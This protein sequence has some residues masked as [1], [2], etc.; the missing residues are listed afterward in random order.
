MGLDR[1]IVVALSVIALILAPAA[2]LRALCVGH[3]CDEPTQ[4]TAGIPFCSLPDRQRDAII[5]GFREG[6]SPDVL[7]VSDSVADERVPLL[8]YGDGFD[9]V[10]IP[11]GTSLDR[12][13]PTLAQAID[14]RR[15]HPEVR[16]GVALE[17]APSST[18]AR[19]VLIVLLKGVGESNFDPKEI[20]SRRPYLD[21][22]AITTAAV[23]GSLPIDA[24]AIATTLGTGGLPYQHGIT[25][26]LIRNDAGR[27]VQA[28]GKGAP[29]S[30]IATLADDLDERS[31]QKARIGLVAT[32]PTDQGLVGGNWYLDNDRDDLHFV[33]RSRAVETARLIVASGYGRDEVPDLLAVAIDAPPATVPR[34]VAQLIALARKASD[35]NLVAAVAGTGTSDNEGVDIARIERAIPG[36][37][38]LIAGSVPGGFFIDQDAVADTGITEDAVIKAIQQTGEFSDVFAGITVT[39]ARYC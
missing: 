29:V 36:P 1:R 6:R 12:V 28:W 33:N 20:T 3:S 15:A 17:G 25:G 26:R 39:F 31:D 19:L 27:L 32:S 30:V 21:E 2:I 24:A 14:F 34:A 9:A 10:E 5:T 22:M 4:S 35:D 11:E 18:G 38:K 37:R 23:T 13:A 8:F 7:A 16:S